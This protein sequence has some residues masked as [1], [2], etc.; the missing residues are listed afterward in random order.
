MENKN[1]QLG[2]F[3]STFSFVEEF[4]SQLNR[5]HG[6]EDK[7][8][9]SSATYFREDDDEDEFVPVFVHE[10][11]EWFP[12]KKKKLPRKVGKFSRIGENIP[13]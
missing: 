7:E 10:I 6:E 5:I 3:E 11:S 13:E 1:F 9:K 2:Q 8:K 4:H 12:L